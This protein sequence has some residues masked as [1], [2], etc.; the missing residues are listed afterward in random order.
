MSILTQ[1]A[2]RTFRKCPR[3]YNYNYIQLYKP[4]IV[5]GPLQFGTVWHQIREVWW[6]AP[7]KMRMSL[8][9]TELSNISKDPDLEL[10]EFILAKLMVMLRGYHER[11]AD[12]IDSLMIVGVEVQ[13]E[14]PLINPRTIR[15]SR[16]YTIQGKLD[17]VIREKDRL[18]MVEEKTAGE[19]L[20]PESPYWRRLEIDPQCSIYFDAIKQIYS[21]EPAGI[22]YF[23][24]VKPQHKPL[25]ETPDIIKKYKKGTNILYAGQR[26]EAETAPEYAMRLSEAVAEDPERYYQMMHVSRL[27]Q[28]IYESQ[29]DVWD[30][31]KAIREA[32]KSGV[33]LRNPDSCIHAFGSTCSFLPVCANRASISDTSLYRKS[34]EA[35]EELK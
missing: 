26:A 21:E 27:P 19:D 29:I 5:T 30:T 22:M 28:D 17:A 25:R 1:T 14:I 4:Q 32:E 35:H 6:K 18:W 9:L 16:I 10:D 33:W 2:I 20:K 23:V 11:W 34:T 8:A 3:L 13:F 15:G 12:Y 31:A 7:S 24:N